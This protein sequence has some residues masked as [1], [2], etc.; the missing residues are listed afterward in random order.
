MEGHASYGAIAEAGLIDLHAAGIKPGP[1]NFTKG[2]HMGE[3]SRIDRIAER[4]TALFLAEQ[5]AQF[6]NCAINLCAT[7]M[8]IPS[9]IEL[10]EE[11][12]EMLKEFG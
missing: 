2:I 1:P 3:P 12:V 5:S 9:L 4:E 6:L 11:H 8:D 7:S 10:L